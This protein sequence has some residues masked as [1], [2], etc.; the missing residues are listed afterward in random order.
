MV[1]VQQGSPDSSSEPS[2]ESLPVCRFCIS[3]LGSRHQGS[4]LALPLVC[5]VPFA[6]S[7]ALGTSRAQRV[8][9]APSDWSLVSVSSGHADCSG[10]SAQGKCSLDFGRLPRAPRPFPLE[11]R[12]LPVQGPDGFVSVPSL[13]PLLV[14]LSLICKQFQGRQACMCTSV[15]VCVCTSVHVCVLMRVRARVDIWEAFLLS[16][17]WASETGSP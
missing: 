9:G 11:Y 17:G 8:K 1:S 12:R 10:D 2:S 3:A 13:P 15:H 4:V 5:C 6:G 14:C 16:P 7:L